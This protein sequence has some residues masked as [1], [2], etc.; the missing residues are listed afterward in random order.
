MHEVDALLHAR[1]RTRVDDKLGETALQLQLAERALLRGICAIFDT[2][3]VTEAS[4][5]TA[6][7]VA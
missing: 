7:R 1:L 2:Q 5:S 3:P 4:D 6:G